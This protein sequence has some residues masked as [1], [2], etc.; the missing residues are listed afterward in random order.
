MNRLDSADEPPADRRRRG[1]L[2]LAH[3]ALPG[4]HGAVVDLA[5]LVGRGD[6]Q[7]RHEVPHVEPVGPAGAGA[8]LLGEPDFFFG[9]VGQCRERADRGGG[10]PGELCRQG[11]VVGRGHGGPRPLHSPKDARDKPDYHVHRGAKAELVLE[12]DINMLL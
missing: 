8:L 10:W 4:D 7:R 5:Q 12:L 3:E 11:G 9:D 1:V 6:R 2:G